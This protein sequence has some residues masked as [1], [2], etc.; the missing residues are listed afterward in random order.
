MLEIKTGKTEA[1]D[2]ENNSFVYVNKGPTF[3]LE[4]SLL[5]LSKWE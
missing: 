3:V 5:S 1:Y 4:H 2:D